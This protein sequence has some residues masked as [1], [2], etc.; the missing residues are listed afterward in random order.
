MRFSLLSNEL[1]PVDDFYLSLLSM[2]KKPLRVLFV[3]K[4]IMAKLERHN[5]LQLFEKFIRDSDSGRRLQKNGKRLGKGT[6]ENYCYLQKL[7]INF[8]VKKNFP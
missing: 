1:V 3:T 7:L 8:E 2:N 4:R 6:I 5:L